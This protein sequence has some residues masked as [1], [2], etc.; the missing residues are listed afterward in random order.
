MGQT[1]VIGLVAGAI[2][3]LLALGIVMV[4][5]GSRVLNFAQAELGTFGLFVALARAR[6]RHAV[7]RRAARRA[8]RAG[9]IAALF[10]VLVVRRMRDAPRLAVAVA[11]IGLLLLLVALELKIWGPSPKFLAARSSGTGPAIFGYRV[12]VTEMIAVALAWSVGLG[13]ERCSFGG[14]TSASAC[15]PPR[16]TSKAVRMVGHPARRVSSFTWV[17]RAA[18]SVPSPRCSSS[19][20]SALPAPAAS[21]PSR[22]SSPRW[23]AALLG[24][25]TSLTHAFV[26]GIAVGVMQAFVGRIFVDSSV[27]GLP[28][29]AVFLVIIGALLLRADNTLE[30]A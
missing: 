3:G 27:P 20:A 19:R 21:G 28:T 13:L 10:E 2:Y 30:A 16:R 26:G 8:R 14:P 5:R 4:Y 22:C 15:S 6:P 17:T 18:C 7:G 25:L 1:L 24:G 9:G 12:S 23:P 29:L 11:T